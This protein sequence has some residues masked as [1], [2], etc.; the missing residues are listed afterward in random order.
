[1]PERILCVIH[2]KGQR[3]GWVRARHSLGECVDQSVRRLDTKATGRPGVGAVR[4]RWAGDQGVTE[5]GGSALGEDRVEP[6]RTI[7]V[8]GRW[9]GVVDKIL[10]VDVVLSPVL[11]HPL[12][13]LYPAGGVS[14]SIDDRVPVLDQPRL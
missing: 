4:R 1:M 10:S 6:I 8:V 7:D 9:I 3:S 11:F 12:V 2:A 14:L 13:G 5:I